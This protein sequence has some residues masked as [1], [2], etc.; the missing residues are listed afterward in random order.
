MA[1]TGPFVK[2]ATVGRRK[3][4]RVIPHYG[5]HGY[6]YGLSNGGLAVTPRGCTSAKQAYF[7][8]SFAITGA[9]LANVFD[10]SIFISDAAGPLAQTAT[11]IVSHYFRHRSTGPT[12]DACG[13]DGPL[14]PSTPVL[15]DS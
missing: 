11:T 7:W 1:E 6:S 12:N 13:S 10:D 5:D 14:D 3:P 4:S 2:R 8:L 9:I 15:P